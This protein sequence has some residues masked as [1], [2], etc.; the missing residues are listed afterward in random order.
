MSPNKEIYY[1]NKTHS[2][3]I[4]SYLLDVTNL[5]SDVT[6]FD[7]DFIG[8]ELLVD[9]VIDFHNGL[10]IYVEDGNVNRKEWFISLP[11]N[12]YWAS[13]G[14]IANLALNEEKDLSL[15]EEKLLS[16]TVKVLGELTETLLVKPFTEQEY[17]INLN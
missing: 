12:L 2:A 9:G 5:I 3:I 17:K 13:R 15:F 16:L 11:N 6:M 4:N 14:Y 10:G 1:L 8:Y 7:E